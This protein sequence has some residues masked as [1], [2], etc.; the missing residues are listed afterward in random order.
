M[1]GKVRAHGGHELTNTLRK[2]LNDK[3]S[4]SLIEMKDL[5]VTKE[6]RLN[7]SIKLAVSASFHKFNVQILF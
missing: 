1:I 4:V 2:L 5:A 6:P 7:P 3:S